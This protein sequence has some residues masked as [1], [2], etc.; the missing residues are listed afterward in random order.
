M[1]KLTL[2]ISSTLWHKGRVSNLRVLY[3]IVLLLLFFIYGGSVIGA[4]RRLNYMLIRVGRTTTSVAI[5]L[6]NSSLYRQGLEIL[7]AEYHLLIPGSISILI[8]NVSFTN[9]KRFKRFLRVYLLSL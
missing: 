2:A 6:R 5:F 4:R 1:F 8:E 7:K 3:L 9:T